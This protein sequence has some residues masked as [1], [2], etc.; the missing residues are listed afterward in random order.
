MVDLDWINTK[1]CLLKI[2]L[3]DNRGPQSGFELVHKRLQK[4]ESCLE[5][6]VEDPPSVTSL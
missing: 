4:S 3:G 6:I 2:A 1:W 5:T